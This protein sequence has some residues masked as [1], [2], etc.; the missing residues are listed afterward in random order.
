MINLPDTKM[1]HLEYQDEWLTIYLDNHKKRNA[2]SS[3]LIDELMEVL[4]LARDKKI[5]RGILI[6][7]KN[8]IFCSGADLDELHQITYNK[9]QS[10][11]MTIDMSTRIGH[12]LNLIDATPKL[13]VSFIEG[14]CIAGG[15]GMACATDVIITMQN[16]VFRLSE[17]RL[18]LTPSQIAP[19]VLRKVDY[20]K[21][22]LL[23]LLGDSIDGKIAYDIGL[24]DYLATTESEVQNHIDQIKAKLNKCSPNAFAITKSVVSK[25]ASINIQKAAELFNE[26]VE[27]P[28][29]KEGLESFFEKRN[30]F[31]VNNKNKS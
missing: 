25:H 11:K 29:G 21:A 2:L 13:T 31:W 22:R 27:H 26:C 10:K 12:L 18:G 30:P 19:Y 1:C 20:S 24:A 14:P 3:E 7:G 5:V 8:N 23:M 4:D 15:F 16:S 17:T 28:E 6:R 9:S